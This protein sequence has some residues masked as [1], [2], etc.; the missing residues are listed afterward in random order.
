M[1]NIPERLAWTRREFAELIER[2][3]EA[4]LS[5]ADAVALPAAKRLLRLLD[6]E[7]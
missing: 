5:N 1:T 2:R 7:L 6:A 4:G 3:E